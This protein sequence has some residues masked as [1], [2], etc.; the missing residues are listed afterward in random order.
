MNG[1]ALLAAG[2][3]F[4]RTLGFVRDMLF[5][6]LL[7][8]AADAFLVAFR[9]PNFMRRLLAEGSLG[10][11][12]GAE[13]GALGSAKSFVEARGA[14]R[15]AAI[16]LFV[17]SL[18]VAVL[19]G[20][21]ARPLLFCIAP[22]LDGETQARGAFLLRLCMPY[23]PLCIFS[24]V[25]FTHASLEGNFRP[26][27]WAPA[28]WNIV[29]LLA[30]CS[31]VV[32]NAA[33]ALPAAAESLLSAGVV[34][35]GLLQAGLGLRCLYPASFRPGGSFG[36][37]TAASPL[38]Q[39]RG[40]ERQETAGEEKIS[41]T[42][43]QSFL[44]ANLPLLRRF[45]R[46]LV[47]AAPHQLHILLGTFM[48]SFAFPGAVSS[49]YF[50]ER[51]VELPLGLVGASL[52][53]ASLP[54]MAA[55]AH[56]GDMPG[57]GLELRRGLLTSAF[58][59]LPAA[60][61]LFVLADALVP[62]FFGHGAATPESVAATAAAMRGYAFAIPALC[63][64]RPLLSALHALG[65]GAKAARCAALSLAPVLLFSLCG[66]LWRANGGF[67]SAPLLWVALGI[68]AGA[69]TNA[70]LLLAT[71]KT[72]GLEIRLAQAKKALARYVCAALG[73]G[74]ALRGLVSL[75]GRPGVLGVAALVLCSA[76]CWLL[77]FR[78][79]GSEEAEAFWRAF[80]ERKR[81]RP[82]LRPY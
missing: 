14:A 46:A 48:A 4:S 25:A 41:S 73:M 5:A 17:C 79:L 44:K 56:K 59:S 13:A 2:T 8:P 74:L 63:A 9:L 49:L 82:R 52:G 66:L 69:W 11:A 78:R 35:G 18:P 50:A 61:G 27:A 26:Q 58:L 80:S 19:I 36:E 81:K 77:L 43:A 40:T 75:T 16:A 53:M 60:V 22:G 68:S 33:S 28:L 34:L 20:L 62:A 64:A 70:L 71:L 30:G 51:L 57:L 3:L 32:L 29:L 1:A 39:K 15:S 23:L 31:A 6:Y 47:G 67:C 76:A 21:L 10:L 72:A 24:A 55:L 37:K 42:R 54:L 45:P 12:Y 65:V 38:P 7:G